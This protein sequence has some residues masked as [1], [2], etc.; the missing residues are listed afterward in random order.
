ML[1]ISKQKRILG[2]VLHPTSNLEIPFTVEHM[3]KVLVSDTMTLNATD[4]G[5]YTVSYKYTLCCITGNNPC[6]WLML[7]TVLLKATMYGDPQ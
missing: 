2:Q 4:F 6:S 1:P 3:V 7:Y 5:T